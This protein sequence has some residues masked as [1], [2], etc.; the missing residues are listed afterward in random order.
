ML[1]L[2]IFLLDVVCIV[3][4]DTKFSNRYTPSMSSISSLHADQNI[5]TFSLSSGLL[6]HQHIGF[7]DEI[8]D[9]RLLSF[10][11]ATSPRDTHLAIATNSSLIKI[12][13]TRTLDARLL[14]GHHDM[15][16][17]LDAGSDGTLLA[18]GSKDKSARIWLPLHHSIPG[19]AK[20]S[21]EVEWRCAAIAEGH[22][23][24]IGA[25]A[26]SRKNMSGRFM[27]TGS[28]DRTVK[29]WD[30][31][32]LPP[33]TTISA[34]SATDALRLKSLMTLKAHEKDINSLDV[35]PN[36][37]L[38]VTGSQD[39]TINVYEVDYVPSTSTKPARGELRLLGTCKGHKRGVWSVKFSKTERYLA[40]GSGDK[41]V[42]LWSLDDFSCLKVSGKSSI[43][44][45]EACLMPSVL[46]DV[47][48]PYQY[49]SEG[50]FHQ[51]W[52]AA[53]QCGVRWLGQTMEYSRRGMRN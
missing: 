5:L 44:G 25:I 1:C 2:F 10:S 42:R 41:T 32:V 17:C 12:Y 47:R 46:T 11:T 53:G 20:D 35:A 8:I 18:S 23:E 6:L 33:T 38:L 51:S 50:G 49:C 16:L 45:E 36:D 27:V 40:S 28:Q 15:V 30:L 7:N 22:A 4:N 37:R 14:S 31:A 43:G 9:A 13:D 26:L 34:S 52:D 3:L 48:R 21:E 29:M 39:K 24:S 19:S